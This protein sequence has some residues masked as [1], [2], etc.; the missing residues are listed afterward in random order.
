MQMSGELR[1][2]PSC[3]PRRPQAVGRSLPFIALLFGETSPVRIAFRTS[4]LSDRFVAGW[5]GPYLE[6]GGEHSKPHEHRS[7][8][9][10]E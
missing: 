4:N 7:D 10:G 5:K 6:A 9:S 1:Y 3:L 2:S 8:D